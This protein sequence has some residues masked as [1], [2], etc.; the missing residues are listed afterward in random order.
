MSESGS[1]RQGATRD[2]AGA[3]RVAATLLLWLIVAGLAGLVWLEAQHP[4]FG[5]PL[6]HPVNVVLFSLCAAFGVFYTAFIWFPRRDRTRHRAAAPDRLT[7][8][9]AFDDY[10]AKF[11][12]DYDNGGRYRNLDWDRY[13]SNE[14]RWR[15]LPDGTV[16]DTITIMRRERSTV[17]AVHF[18]GREPTEIWS[19]HITTTADFDRLMEIIAAYAAGQRAEG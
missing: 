2:A 1:G 5:L 10:A 15:L 4:F 11:G 16:H 9:Q 19:G 17:A 8:N 18:A 7:D 6:T 12:W 13:A 14:H 3:N